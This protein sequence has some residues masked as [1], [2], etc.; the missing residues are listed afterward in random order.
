VYGSIVDLKADQARSLC[1]HPAPTKV[2]VVQSQRH[3][4]LHAK[5]LYGGQKMTRSED[6]VHPIL[7]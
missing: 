3:L 5:Q 2:D 4:S 7:D 1:H 6:Q